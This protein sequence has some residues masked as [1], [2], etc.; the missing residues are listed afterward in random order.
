VKWEALSLSLVLVAL[1]VG[2]PDYGCG[3]PARGN[4]EADGDGER[5]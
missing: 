2:N 3:K 4:S 1:L 5:G